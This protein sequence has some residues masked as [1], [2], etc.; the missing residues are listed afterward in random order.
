M[1]EQ[2]DWLDFLTNDDN[3]TLVRL[4]QKLQNTPEFKTLMKEKDDE[5]TI[6][7]NNACTD[8]RC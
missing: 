8:Y 2:V 7:Q 1:I 6:R 3:P 5:C 4:A